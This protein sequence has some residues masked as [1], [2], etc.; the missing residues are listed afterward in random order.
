MFAY[1]QQF[2]LLC[3][4]LNAIQKPLTDEDKVSWILKGPDRD[5]NA[6]QTNIQARDKYPTF[7]ETTSMLLAQE[8]L[9]KSYDGLPT[10]HTSTAF[11]AQIGERPPY[12]HGRSNSHSGGRSYGRG[13]G[14]QLQSGTKNMTYR[15][16]GQVCG[17]IGYTALKRWY[18]FD[19]SY[20]EKSSSSEGVNQ[21][22]ATLSCMTMGLNHGSLTLGP[23]HM[24]LMTQVNFLT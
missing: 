12:N 10:D 23:L 20:Q 9:L 21:A 19:E 4:E 7:K 13:R 15:L 6:V 16:T 2:R 24:L 18:Q 22:F 8:A 17:K 11:V 5:Y 1:I 3:D 14:Q